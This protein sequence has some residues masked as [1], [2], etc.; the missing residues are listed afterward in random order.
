MIT[1]DAAGIIFGII[2][3]V[4]V[5]ITF[6]SFVSSRPTRK[7]VSESIATTVQ[8]FE[9]VVS[10]EMTNVKEGLATIN[11]KLDEM[12]KRRTK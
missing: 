5:L 11:K 4:A 9:K 1:I 10:T 8:A 12:P 2:G 6:L 7:E 3:V